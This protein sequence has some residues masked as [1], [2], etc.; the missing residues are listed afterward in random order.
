MVGLRQFT[1][2]LYFRE[3]PHYKNAGDPSDMVGASD[4]VTDLAS[5]QPQIHDV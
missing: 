2:T 3:I 4:V 1:V 5:P